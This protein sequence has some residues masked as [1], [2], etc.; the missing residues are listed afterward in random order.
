MFEAAT[1][2]DI[3]ADKVMAD[4]DGKSKELCIDEYLCVI[5]EGLS[6]WFWLRSKYMI[7]VVCVNPVTDIVAETEDVCTAT[8]VRSL[9]E[10]DQQRSWS[11]H[12]VPALCIISDDAR[13]DIK[14]TAH[15]M[16]GVSNTFVSEY[17]VDTEEFWTDEHTVGKALQYA[18]DHFAE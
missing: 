2:D 15:E 7:P 11:Q 14:A 9:I 1:D 6:A 5:A 3:D 10:L 16:F 4:V 8:V 18:L 12:D 17:D 13:D